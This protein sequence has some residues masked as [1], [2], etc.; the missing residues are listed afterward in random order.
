MTKSW[1]E[2]T[3]S[4]KLQASGKPQAPSFKLV[5]C[6]FPGAWCLEFE[7]FML[8]CPSTLSVVHH[9]FAGFRLWILDCS[10]VAFLRE[11]SLDWIIGRAGLH[12]PA[13]RPQQPPGANHGR[14][15]HRPRLERSDGEGI[16]EID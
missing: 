8:P 3:P 11:Q 6:R 12:K 2:K 15:G 14:C 10:V 7:A 13:G 16:T 1:Q 9:A 4:F 5:A